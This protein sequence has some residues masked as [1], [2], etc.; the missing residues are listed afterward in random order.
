MAIKGGG[1]SVPTAP[2]PTEAPMGSEGM[3]DGQGD[4]PV[5]FGEGAGYAVD[6]EVGPDMGPDDV[7]AMLPE[8]SYVL[9]A[10]A[11]EMN[12]PEVDMMEAQAGPPM[13]NSGSPRMIRAKLTKGERVLA[14][15]VVARYR[16]RIEQM[17]QGGLMKRD[18][19]VMYRQEGGET[20]P[21]P[22]YQDDRLNQV[23]EALVN[24]GQRDFKGASAA[25]RTP[26]VDKN[27]DK[28]EAEINAEVVKLAEE[29][30]GP[31][32]AGSRC[33]R[34]DERLDKALT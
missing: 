3:M 11:T 30:E 9:N 19:M 34:P 33:W 29:A 5:S 21:T 18:A 1:T 23:G 4:G 26:E 12:G 10:E 31:R 2:L 16:D 13:M 28:T 32:P 8:G 15:H 17:N 27:K 7:D 14:P 24:I 6:G 20:A 22:W 25:L